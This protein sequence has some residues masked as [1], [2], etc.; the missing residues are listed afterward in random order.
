MNWMSKKQMEDYE[1]V[2]LIIDGVKTPKEFYA[3][4]KIINSG[5]Y[6]FDVVNTARADKRFFNSA[7]FAEQGA[8]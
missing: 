5:R 8:K 6:D 7:Q 1:A 3:A 2:C 4:C